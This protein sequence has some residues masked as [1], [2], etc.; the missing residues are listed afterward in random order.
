MGWIQCGTKKRGISCARTFC[1][2]F[3]CQSSNTRNSERGTRGLVVRGDA[4]AADRVRFALALHD[5]RVIVPPCRQCTDFVSYCVF[6]GTSMMIDGPVTRTIGREVS[7]QRP[8]SNTKDL[9]REGWFYD[10][11][12][13]AAGRPRASSRHIVLAGVVAGVVVGSVGWR[14][15][16]M[17]GGVAVGRSANAGSVERVPS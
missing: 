9:P 7:Q 10:R 16:G 4:V 8:V 6:G 17:M 15:S 1:R 14:Y 2:E 3:T 11:S 5:V 12:G 13:V